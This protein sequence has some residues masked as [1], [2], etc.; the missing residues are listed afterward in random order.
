MIHKTVDCYDYNYIFIVHAFSLLLI[1][2]TK[3][4]DFSDKCNH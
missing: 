2:C 4:S 1:A 3:F